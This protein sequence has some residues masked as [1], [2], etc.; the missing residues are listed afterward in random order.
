MTWNDVGLITTGTS[1]SVSEW[2]DYFGTNSNTSYLLKNYSNV[3]Y[4]S[5]IANTSVLNNTTTTMNLQS[6]TTSYTIP[7]SWGNS[8]MYCV[9][10]SVRPATSEN[11]TG[12]RTT[13]LA[14]NG[15]ITKSNTVNAITLLT[16]GF[17][18]V[19]YIGR[20]SSGDALSIRFIQNSTAT[21]TYETIMDV[22]KISD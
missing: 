20:L 2:N 12:R 10:A 7:S 5:F 11:S 18:P 9:Y 4:S 13:S 21:F 6:S 3:Y 16:S 19:T 1:I 14:I 22:R 8:G 15:V 17:Y